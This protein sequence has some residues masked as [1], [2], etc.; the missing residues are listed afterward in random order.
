MGRKKGK[1]KNLR[2]RRLLS[3]SSDSDESEQYQYHIPNPRYCTPKTKNQGIFLD[4]IRSSNTHIVVCQGSAGTGKTLISC[5][6]GIRCLLSQEINRIIITRPAVCADEDI[7]FL[8]GDL[9]DKMKPFTQPLFDNF[10]KILSRPYVEN[11]IKNELIQIVPLAYMR[12]RTFEDKF[13]IADEMQNASIEQMV[14]LMTRIGKNSKLIIIGDPSQCDRKVKSNGLADL[15]KRINSASN[16][17]K[18]IKLITLEK[19]D[20]QREEVVKEVINHIYN[21]FN[22]NTTTTPTTS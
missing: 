8:P 19:K 18:R 13:I 6:E 9:D 20:I 10:E 4:S 21:D 7:G 5:Q 22:K 1:E 17:L 12:G 15:V 14:M 16:I 2:R 11:M 3:I